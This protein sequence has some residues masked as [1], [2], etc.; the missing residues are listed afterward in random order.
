MTVLVL[1]PLFLVVLAAYRLLFSPLAHIPGPKL[2]ALTRWYEAYYEIALNGQYS[3]HI[4]HLHDIYGS[5]L[6]VELGR[7]IGDTP[8][9][10]LCDVIRSD[11]SDCAGRDSCP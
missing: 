8:T 3:F 5:R 10:Y 7:Y 4:D 2:A 1:S 9:D 11:Y 6:P